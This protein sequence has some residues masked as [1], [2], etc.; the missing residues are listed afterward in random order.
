[1]YISY[2]KKKKTHADIVREDCVASVTPTSPSVPAAERSPQVGAVF[3]RAGTNCKFC[4]LIDV[5]LTFK[6]NKSRLV[7]GKLK[8]L[9]KGKEL[10]F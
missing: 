6:K 10:L 8:E 5:F 2:E 9:I 4:F 1:M 3:Q 7:S